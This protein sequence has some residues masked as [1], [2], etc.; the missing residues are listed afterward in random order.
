MHVNDSQA[1]QG[2]AFMWDTDCWTHAGDFLLS[3]VERCPERRH[4]VRV[5]AAHVDAAHAQRLHHEP[6][7][8]VDAQLQWSFARLSPKRNKSFHI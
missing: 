3:G 1:M 6:E 8:A 5:E 7:P 2:N 4:S